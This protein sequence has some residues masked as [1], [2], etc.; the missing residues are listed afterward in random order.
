MELV[1]P[2]SACGMESA[3]LD[4]EVEREGVWSMIL[5]LLLCHNMLQKTSVLS[6][7]LVVHRFPC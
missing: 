2:V 4:L 6:N 3:W 5:D 1:G 7:D